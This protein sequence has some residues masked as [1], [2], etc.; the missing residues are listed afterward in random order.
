MQTE[1]RI[2]S[3][4]EYYAKVPPILLKDNN[5]TGQP[6]YNQVLNLLDKDKILKISRETRGSEAYVK[7]FDGYQHLVVML[8]GV[9]KHF[10]SLR[11]LILPQLPFLII[12]LKELA[13]IQNQGKKKGGM[14][15]HTVMK[16]HVGVPMVVQLTSAAKH[17]HYL[18][19]EVHLPKDSTLAMDRGY[20]DIAQFQRLTEEGVCF[21]GPIN[22]YVLYRFYR[23]Y[24]K[25]G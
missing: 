14:K 25:S 5:F 15:V 18:L 3:L 23:F 1:C 12:Y 6:V 20:I 24:G 8:F 13:D 2:S 16:Y 10:D 22:S 19:K 21:Y 11:E 7:R 17:D 9:L 4:L